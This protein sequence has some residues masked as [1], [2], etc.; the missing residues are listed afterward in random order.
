MHSYK[1]SQLLIYTVGIVYIHI[2]QKK[3]C[4]TAT[5]SNYSVN[6]L[7]QLLSRAL[8]VLIICLLIKDSYATHFFSCK[9]VYH[10][11]QL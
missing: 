3:L 1:H 5:K 4:D 6:L 11:Y 7:R 10:V 8:Y 9:I 2:T